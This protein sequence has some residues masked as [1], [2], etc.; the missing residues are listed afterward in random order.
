MSPG[1]L[2]LCPTKDNVILVTH[3]YSGTSPAARRCGPGDAAAGY[4]DA[5]IGSGKAIDT[6]RFF[7]ISSD[8]LVNLNVKGSHVVTTGPVSINPDTGGHLD[9][10]LAIAKAGETIREFL[11]E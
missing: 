1:W 11:S 3:F 6:D 4:W 2:G 8:T 9:S 5:I 10:V 7:V